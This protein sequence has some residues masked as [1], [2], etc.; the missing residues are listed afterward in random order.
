[1]LIIILWIIFIIIIVSINN[2]NNCNNDSNN[3]IILLLKLV[4]KTYMY[5]AI[6]ETLHSKTFYWKQEHKNTL[7]ENSF[8]WNSF[9]QL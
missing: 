2:I 6:L 7:Q 4:T 9:L 8:T 3:N 1:M 5:A